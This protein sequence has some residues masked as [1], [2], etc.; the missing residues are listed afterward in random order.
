MTTVAAALRRLPHRDC[1]RRGPRRSCQ[2]TNAEQITAAMERQ[3]RERFSRDDDERM[4]AGLRRTAEE[5]DRLAQEAKEQEKQRPAAEPQPRTRDPNPA[6]LEHVEGPMQLSGVAVYEGFCTEDMEGAVTD[7]LAPLLASPHAARW[8][9]YRSKDA[10]PLRHTLEFHGMDTCAGK[11]S[12]VLRQDAQTRREV[13]AVQH[14][15]KTF[16]L[17]GTAWQQGLVTE[18]PDSFR[19]NEYLDARS[20]NLRHKDPEIQGKWWATA[21]LLSEACL[22]FYHVKSNSV[23]RVLLPERSLLVAE[24]E[25]VKEWS[26]ALECDP[27]FTFRGRKREKDYRISV[28]MWAMDHSRVRLETPETNY[29]TVTSEE[30]YARRAR[31]KAV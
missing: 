20:G 31:A 11:A 21:S 13:V 16:I 26:H 15:P 5:F 28:T 3:Y 17:C 10:K 14:A 23:W 6:L 29:R 4:R 24:G 30:V 12:V 1:L 19:V 9:G 7:E 27:E 18:P 22:T 8:G 2:T 25:A